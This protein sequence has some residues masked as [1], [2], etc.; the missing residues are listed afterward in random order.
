MVAI[1]I[2][3]TK[4]FQV[5]NEEIERELEQYLDSDDSEENKRE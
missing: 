2:D 4:E 5:S 1:T 3:E